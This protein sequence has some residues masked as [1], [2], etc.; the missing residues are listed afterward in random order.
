MARKPKITTAAEG[1]NLPIHPVGA[2]NK[3]VPPA[4]LNKEQIEAYLEYAFADWDARRAELIAALTQH[5]KAN[6][7]INDDRTLGDVGENVKMARALT[8]SAEDKRVETTAPFLLGQRTVMAWVKKWTLPIEGAIE[9]L[10]R[11]MND[12]GDRKDRAARAEALRQQQEAEKKA[13]EAAEAASKALRDNN[14]AAA[15]AALDDVV[16]A[17]A[18]QIEA[19][20]VLDSRPAETTRTYGTYGGVMSGQRTWGWKV[21]D[22]AA[23]PDEYKMVNEDM[24]KAKAKTRDPSGKP[25]AVIPGIEWVSS[26]RMGVR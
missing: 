1:A 19:A 25:T 18:E 24:L 4:P 7:T 13:A 21:T 14:Q 12:Y 8:R 17:D 3:P 23:L 16:D 11:A 26:F 6:A 20:A 22:F 5:G 10:Q 15:S 9:P 2:G